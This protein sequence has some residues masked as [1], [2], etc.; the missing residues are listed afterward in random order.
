MPRLH[1]FEWEDLPWFPDVFRRFITDH[2]VFHMS[3]AFRPAIPRLADAMRAT[4]H[5]TVVDLCSGSGGPLPALLPRLSETVGWPV[6]A[7]LTDLYPNVPA[8]RRARSGSGGRI[9]HRAAPVNAM[10][11]PAGLEGF[12]TMFTAL[13]HFRPAEARRILADAAAKDVPIAVFEAQERRASTL[14]VL[15]VAMLLSAFLLTPFLGRLSAGRL[16]LTYVVPLAPLFF[17]WDTAVSCLR[18]YSTRELRALTEGLG[19]AR[20]N[21]EIGRIRAG[22]YLGPYHVTYL[23]GRP[24][25]RG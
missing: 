19:G 17:A 8:F 21:W 5:D 23:I 13:H 1:V 7:V 20:Y 16:L 6:N 4:G 9:G 18:T 11:C 3:R 22:G 2:L 24:A 10:E 14:L 12:R 25:A 15:P